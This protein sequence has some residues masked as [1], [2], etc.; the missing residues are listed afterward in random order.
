LK[1][2]SGPAVGLD[3]LRALFPDV[4]R[5]V[6]V[7]LL[8][9]YRRVWRKRY[10]QD[11]W[12]LI[13]NR[14]GA[15]LAIDFSKP[16]EPVDG[17][18]GQLF[19]VRDL[20]SHYQLA[21][22][23]VSDATAEAA[24]AVL[25]ELF[26]QHG[27]PLIVKCDNGSAFVSKAFRAFLAEQGVLLLYSPP[28]TPGY[29]GGVERGNGVMKT[30]TQQHAAA[31]QHPFRWTSD[32]VEAARKLANTLS[33]PWGY[34]GPTPEEAWQSRKRL[35]ETERAAFRAAVERERAAA[36]QELDLPTGD[37]N[38]EDQA[39][40]D[41]LALQRALC[42]LGYLEMH[43]ADR[44]R[45]A[46][47]LSRAELAKRAVEAGIATDR[48]SDSAVPAPQNASPLPSDS[49]QAAITSLA[50]D[51]ANANE[52][53]PAVEANV[54]L[55]MPSEP[56]AAVESN[57]ATVNTTPQ[58]IATEAAPESE[59]FQLAPP[60]AADTMREEAD[61]EPG[62]RASPSPPAPAAV[63]PAKPPWPL[64]IIAPL[65]ARLKAAKIT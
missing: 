15:V 53:P 22:L 41:R 58:S 25:R 62:A 39:R 3:A 28:M 56:A 18:F 2:V 24:I 29:N 37:L 30:Y 27:T 38:R 5:A 8:R 40:L 61:G 17:V 35:D 64:R 52:S 42:A 31:E 55:G 26:A 11:G 60:L 36:R 45:K 63:E 48:A 21:W 54:P 19:A 33:R 44:A 20:A 47:R 7:D 49:A 43:R 9:R 16:R 51:P 59:R 46:K 12:R 6:L 1:E 65:F 34:R 57:N 50:S 14:P 32:D 10:R 4:P 13:W 23:P